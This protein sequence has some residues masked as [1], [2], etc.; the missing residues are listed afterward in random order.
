MAK[1]D[2]YEFAMYHDV[3][4]AHVHGSLNSKSKTRVLQ[5][6]PPQ[7]QLIAGD[8]LKKLGSRILFSFN[9]I[10]RRAGCKIFSNERAITLRTRLVA[11]NS[12]S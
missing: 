10:C 3:Q 1:A 9:D 11:K 5:V 6:S 7:R 4:S 12:E 8:L 2:P